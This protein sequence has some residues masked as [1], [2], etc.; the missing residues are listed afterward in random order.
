MQAEQECAEDDVVAG[1]PGDEVDLGQLV[2]GTCVA[3]TGQASGFADAVG[4]LP[5]GSMRP[6]SIARLL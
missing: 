3:G 5:A 4:G 6:S 2:R 1:G